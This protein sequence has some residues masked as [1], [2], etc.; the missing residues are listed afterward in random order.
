M[1]SSYEMDMATGVQFLDEA[2]GRSL[3]ANTLGKGMNPSILP[4]AKGK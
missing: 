2:V 4:P 1:L 3:C